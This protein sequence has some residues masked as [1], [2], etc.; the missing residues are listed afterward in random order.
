MGSP[1]SGFIAEAVLQQLESLVFK[2]HKLKFW[3]RYGDDTFPVLSWDQL[4]TFKERLNTV[5]PD[6]QFTMEEEDNNQLAFLD[7]LVCRKDCGGL[8]TKVFRKAT[9]AMQVLNFNSKCPISH[10]RGCVK[11]LFRR[12]KKDCSEPEDKVA[13]L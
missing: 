5:F 7:A 9:N 12:V 10:K 1:I 8:K 4:L 11:T 13:E 2:H 3:A 6:M